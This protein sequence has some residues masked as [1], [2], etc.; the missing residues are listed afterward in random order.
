M[1]HQPEILFVDDDP[2]SGELMRRFSQGARFSCRVFSNPQAALKHFKRQG[3]DLIVSDLRMPDMSGLELLQAIR[4]INSE[5]PF[6]II[7]G[8]ANVDDTIEAMRLGASNFIKKPFDMDELQI[9]IDK[10]LGYRALQEENR[11]L[12]QQLDD[13]QQHYGMIGHAP[14]LLGIHDI[15]NKISDIRC[16]IIIEGESGTGKELVARA[17]H[18]QS[19]FAAQPF[20]VIDCGAL[21]DTLLE[22]E[23]FG[24]EKG[25]FTSAHQNKTGLL[26]AASGGTVFLDEIGNISDS[27]QMKLMRVIQEQQITRVGGTQ[28]INIDVR[29]I[30]ATNRQLEDMVRQKQ[31][32]HDLYHRLN[33]VKIHVPPLRERREDI[34][35]LVAYFV[36][37]L[38]RQYQREVSHFDA[39]SMKL[40][41]DYDWPGNI[42]ELSNLIERHIVL[43]DAPLMHIEQLSTTTSG[44]EIDHDH[45]HLDELERRYILKILKRCKNNREQTAATLG[46][47]KSTLWRKLQSYDKQ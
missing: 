10:T 42:R 36:D 15:I 12:K 24:H 13:R 11:Q 16:N 30:V 46:I 27:M 25:A 6:I 34:P 8:Y 38:A 21:T 29:F 20:I 32:R 26:E 19:Q 1:N 39:A 37:K 40:L 45:P 23:L 28:S 43:A 33:V 7:T 35:E 5:T 31:F 9:L 4:Q 22:S 2:R 44:Q 18:F 3:A 47:N 14:A 41:L 17:I